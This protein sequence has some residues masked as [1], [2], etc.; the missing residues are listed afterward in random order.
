MTTFEELEALYEKYNYKQMD[1]DELYALIKRLLNEKDVYEHFFM[2]EV[3]RREL[4]GG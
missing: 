4:L 3:M 2:Y 1:N